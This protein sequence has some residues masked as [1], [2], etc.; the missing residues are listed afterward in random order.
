M[1]RTYQLL[2]S[3]LFVCFLTPAWAHSGMDNVLS[4]ESGLMHPWLGHDHLIVMFAVG[5]YA[6]RLNGHTA[7]GLPFAFL[8]FMIGGAIVVFLGTA[9]PGVEL[10]ILLSL[11]L[12]GALLIS[13]KRPSAFLLFAS[14]AD[15]AFCHGYAHAIEITA[16]THAAYYLFGLVSGTALLIGLGFLAG[17]LCRQQSI[18]LRILTGVVSMTTG[19][20]AFVH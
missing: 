16:G 7:I 12:M 5:L 2:F 3:I 8:V 1:Q 18:N 15:F 14:M 4:F 11:I 17:R 9:V 13:S 19:V 10:G 6:S 20:L